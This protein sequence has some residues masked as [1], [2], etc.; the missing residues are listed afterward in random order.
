MADL[1]KRAPRAA[2]WAFKIA[3]A[4][5]TLAAA[6]ESKGASDVAFHGPRGLLG[7]DRLLVCLAPEVLLRQGA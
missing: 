5:L 6:R 3:A 7:H 1:R 4:D 2:S